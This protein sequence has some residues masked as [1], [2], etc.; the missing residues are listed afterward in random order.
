MKIAIAA[1][2]LCV[3][4]MKAQQK[5]DCVYPYQPDPPCVKQCSSMVV[6]SAHSE[7]QLTTLLGFSPQDASKIWQNRS[8]LLKAACETASQRIAAI[9]LLSANLEGSITR[10]IGEDH[11]NAFVSRFR[12][13]ELKRE[14]KTNVFVSAHS[15]D[16]E[17]VGNL[18]L[19]TADK[20][21]QPEKRFGSR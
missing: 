8:S 3:V 21:C 14:P 13:L 9:S 7:K 5:C 1:F 10:L 15:T 11:Y 6:M 16:A 4:P 20:L 2:V 17:A 12:A 18:T 19:V